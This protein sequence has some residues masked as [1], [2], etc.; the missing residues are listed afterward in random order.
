MQ[1]LHVPAALSAV[2]DDPNLVSCA[3]VGSAGG[4]GS[5]GWAGRADHTPC[6]GV[7]RTGRQPRFEGA[8][9][10]CWHGRRR[11]FD[12]RHG[13]A[14][15]RRDGPVVQRH[16]ARQRR[17][18]S[19]CAPSP[20]GMSASSTRVASR[21]LPRLA[22]QALHHGRRGAAGVAGHRRH[23]HPNRRGY[24]K[25]AAGRGYTGASGFES[26]R[27]PPRPRAGGAGDRCRQAIASNT[28]T[29]ALG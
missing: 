7:G 24:A 17:W 14:P 4:A 20:S 8:G 1:V 13:P 25:Q 9:A 28:I 3:G 23:C 6:A 10:G 22:G 27:S 26:R 18:A 21:F 2:F 12:Q 15:A 16:P 29:Y 19:S 5:S 11:R